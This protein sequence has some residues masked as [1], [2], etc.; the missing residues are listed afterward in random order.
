MKV[1]ADIVALIRDGRSDR[2]IARELGIS[3]RTAGTVR[4]TVGAPPA[5]TVYTLTPEQM[6][7]TFARPTYTGGHMDWTGPTNHAGTPVIKR[8]HVTYSARGMAFRRRY[9]RD[10]V[11]YVRATCD[12]PGC[13]AEEHVADAPMR[14]ELNAQ[15]NAI[16]GGAR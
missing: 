9:G 3:R 7:H 1:R 11:G 8:Q 15:Y 14:A 16:F 13:V 6:W 2:A 4:R 12:R 10:P 5:K